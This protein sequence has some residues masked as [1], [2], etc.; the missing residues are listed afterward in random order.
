MT[1]GEL[2]ECLENV[3]DELKVEVDG[4]GYDHWEGIAA[5]VAIRRGRV[6][7]RK[8]VCGGPKR[9]THYDPHIVIRSVSF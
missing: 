3:P 1:V 2:K 4:G 9:H 7:C 5:Q 8:H 6:D